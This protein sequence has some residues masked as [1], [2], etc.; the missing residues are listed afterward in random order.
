MVLASARQMPSR[1]VDLLGICFLRLDLWYPQQPMLEN[2]SLTSTVGC[3]SH[4]NASCPMILDN[5][6]SALAW[7]QTPLSTCPL[8]SSASLSL[9][10]F[11]WLSSTPN[12]IVLTTFTAVLSNSSDNTTLSSLVCK[13]FKC[14]VPRIRNEMININLV[15]ERVICFY[16]HSATSE[17]TYFTMV[18]T[19]PLERIFFHLP[20]TS[21]K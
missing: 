9:S 15:G 21:F 5:T 11:F 1:L 18:N 19:Y 6:S 7:D 17:P 13:V 12:S 8:S 4:E 10:W 3:I 20:T 16:L 2:F 14:T